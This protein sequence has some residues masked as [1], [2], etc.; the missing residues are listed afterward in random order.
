M[1]KK[2]D[3]SVI[4][5]AYNASSY[6]K[7]AI[8]S[9]YRQN[10]DW[11]L[12][13][14]DDAST[15]TTESVV[16]EFLQDERIVYIKNEQ[17]MGVAQSRNLGIES[18]QG[19][20]IAFLDSDDRWT[21]NKLKRQLELMR[22][23]DAVL[24]STARALMNQQGVLTG[25][26]IDVPNKIDY[27]T[28]LYGN[29]ISLSSAMVRREIALEFPMQQEQ[30][31]EDYIFWLQILKK[32]KVAYGINE[33]MLEYRVSEKSKSGNKLRSAAMTF[34]VYRYIGLNIFQCIYYFAAYAVNGVKKH[35]L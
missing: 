27:K 21:E 25:K 13:I 28:L 1:R 10:V 34:G 2:I 7:E 4:M 35:Y 22:Q 15:D 29:C 3:V 24:C 23:K 5:P 16:Q 11:E 31:H 12:I 17:N 30:L 8:E 33:P 9:V 19:E 32:Y 14:I 6:I 20:Y 26:V 18:A